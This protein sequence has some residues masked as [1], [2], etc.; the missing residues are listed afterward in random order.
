VCDRQ[1][2]LDSPVG[3]VPDDQQQVCSD[4]AEQVVEEASHHPLGDRRKRV[5]LVYVPQIEAPA[6]VSHRHGP[7]GQVGDDVIA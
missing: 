4:T 6:D 5:D 2:V 7:T 3:R 1:Q